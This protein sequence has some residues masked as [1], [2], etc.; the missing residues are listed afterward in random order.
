MKIFQKKF[1][2]FVGIA[3]IIALLILNTS[4]FWL[5]PNFT[6]FAEVRKLNIYDVSY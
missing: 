3:I 6:S 2:M 1:K 4:F 5:I